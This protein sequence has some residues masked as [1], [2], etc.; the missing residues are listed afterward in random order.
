[1]LLGDSFT[2]M[3]S[4]DP[5]ASAR[6]GSSQEIKAIERTAPNMSHPTGTH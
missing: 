4:A 5:A 6:T 2:V 1:M 3:V